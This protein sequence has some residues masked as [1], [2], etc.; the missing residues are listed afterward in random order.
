M[1]KKQFTVKVL[2]HDHAEHVFTARDR[3]NAREIAARSVEEGLW[4]IL[5]GGREEFFGPAQVHKAIVYPPGA[6][7]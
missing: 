7:G 5:P 2:M 4:V 1:P 3:N 6:R